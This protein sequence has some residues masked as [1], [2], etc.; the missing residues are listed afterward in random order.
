ML[1]YVFFS[2]FDIW[3]RILMTHREE[4]QIPNYK[5]LS[6]CLDVSRLNPN[7]FDSPFFIV[8]ALGFIKSLNVNKISDFHL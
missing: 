6:L 8:K 3:G 1:S 2:K 7:K 4:H 5:F